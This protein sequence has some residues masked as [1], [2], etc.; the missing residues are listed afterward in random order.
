MLTG[1]P[2]C[3]M[4]WANNRVT[5]NF[6]IKIISVS[7]KGRT[8]I[9][10][11]P[12]IILCLVIFCIALYLFA[13]QIVPMGMAAA[14]TLMLY[15]ATGCVQP[16]EA[17]ALFG[18]VNVV[19]L[20][21]MSVVGKAFLRTQFVNKCVD[22]LVKISA[23]KYMVAYVGFILVAAF[24]SNSGIDPTVLFLILYPLALKICD[25]FNVSRTKFLHPWL[26]GYVACMMSLPLSGLVSAAARNNGFMESYGFT[27][28]M[29]FMDLCIASLPAAGVSLL[30]AIFVAPKLAPAQPVVAIKNIES[31]SLDNE[32]PLP[33]FQEKAATIIF[34][35]TIIVLLLSKRLGLQPYQ[36]SLVAGILVPTCGILNEKEVQQAIPIGLIFLFVGS[37]SIGLAM[38]NT[39]AGEL[40]GN[41][42]AKVLGGTRNNL[43]VGAVFFLVP[44]VLTQFMMNQTAINCLMPIVLLTCKAIGANPIGAMILLNRGG[45]TAYCTPM[46]MAACSACA[47]VGGY[48]IKSMA[49]VGIPMTIVCAI[50]SVIWT[51]TIFP[52]FE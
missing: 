26:L 29:D 20:V 13:S 9:T 48:D 17:V 31:K 30:Y 11:T 27:E 36:I 15:F 2:V 14:I 12:Q 50:I 44:C 49:K 38:V 8:I 45:L 34:F 5:T 25:R 41:L 32:K 4:I 3:C 40:I 39:G 46:A 51:M 6:T 18:N 28:T 22:F 21:G 43:I 24:L 23:G 1:I 10:M 37:M 33:P 47:D 7:F 35:G 52:C 19:V 16:Q 42:L